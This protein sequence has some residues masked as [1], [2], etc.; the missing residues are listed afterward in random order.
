MKLQRGSDRYSIPV[1]AFSAW[2]GTG[3]TTIIEKLISVFKERGLRVAVIKH[4]AHDFEI[5]TPGKDSWRFTNAGADI[6]VISSSAKTAVI[7]QRSL[8]LDE[9][10]SGIYYADIILVE[11]YNNEALPCIGISRAATGKGFRRP[12]DEYIA[13][14]TDEDLSDEYIHA[15]VFPLDDIQGLADFMLSFSR[16]SC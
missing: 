1:F 10:L 8:S 3:K 2:S 7:E 5:D 4:D 13:L 11:G 6:T 14:V 9:I 12:P 15:A 16:S